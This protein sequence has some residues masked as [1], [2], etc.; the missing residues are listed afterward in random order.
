MK[1]DL[2]NLIKEMDI[3]WRNLVYTR[4]YF[5]CVGDKCIGFTALKTPGYYRRFG[6]DIEHHLSAPLTPEKKNE[7]NEIGHWINQNFII[8]LSALTESYHLH[9]NGIDIDSDL[10]GAN[11]L[12]IVKLLRHRFAHSSG[13]YDPKNKN[14]KKIMKLIGDTIGISINGRNDWPLSIKTV[15]EE[16]LKGCKAYAE[17]KLK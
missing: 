16:L 6:I 7:I 9:S 17:E 2:S 5:P 4:G 3:L 1:K 10:Q 11:H 12:K 15:L 13:R 14:D 8:R